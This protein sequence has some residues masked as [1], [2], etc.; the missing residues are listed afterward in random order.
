MYPSLISLNHNSSLICIVWLL[1]V[2][3]SF[4]E[5]KD[6]VSSSSSSEGEQGNTNTR[7][8][9]KN[10]PQG[11][12]PKERSSSAASEKEE[13]IS[14]DESSDYENISRNHGVDRSKVDA[15]EVCYLL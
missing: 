7:F 8:V 13:Q 5:Q 9:R 6:T 1:V 2:L 11:K 12:K 15:A 4:G 10:F 3:F 14:V